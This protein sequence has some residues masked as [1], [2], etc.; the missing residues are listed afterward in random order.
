MKNGKLTH[1]QSTMATNIYQAFLCALALLQVP[2]MGGSTQQRPSS[3][4]GAHA[5]G[6]T[7]TQ[8]VAAGKTRQHG[9]GTGVRPGGV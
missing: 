6:E 7:S 4:H 9:G 2:R 8:P 5:A 1:L 3:F